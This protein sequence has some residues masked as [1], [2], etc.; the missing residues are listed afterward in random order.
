[1]KAG[2]TALHI[3]TKNNHEEVA[4][5]LTGHGANP[6][7]RAS[8]GLDVAVSHSNKVVAAQDRML[9]L[10]MA[11]SRGNL[12]IARI[13]G[14]RMRQLQVLSHSS[15]GELSHQGWMAGASGEGEGGGGRG[16]RGFRR[17]RALSV[18]FRSWTRRFTSREI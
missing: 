13:L 17:V 16:S 9:P 7:L 12:V 3:G 4:K 8:V 18:V 5:L 10:H 11:V 14:E 6:F 15:R 1:M 2:M